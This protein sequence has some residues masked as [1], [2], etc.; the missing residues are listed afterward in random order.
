MKSD[1]REQPVDLGQV[2]DIFK[3]ENQTNEI[4][5]KREFSFSSTNIKI[6]LVSSSIT[7]HILGSNRQHALTYQEI[8]SREQEEV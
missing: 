5:K 3:I 8:S 4:M 2:L 7:N 1:V 6:T